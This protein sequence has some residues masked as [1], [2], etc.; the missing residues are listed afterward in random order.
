M[1][2]DFKFGNTAKEIG[3]RTLS[4]RETPWFEW[5][6]FMGETPE[7]LALVDYVEY[8]LH[9]TFPDPIRISED[10]NS[11]FS[12][13]SSGWGEF[14]IFITIYLKDGQEVETTHYLT[15]FS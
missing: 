14:T 9:D 10:V 15:L 1:S 6:V 11:K 8:R 12:L 13:S 7:K 2:P 4:K 5:T 3:K